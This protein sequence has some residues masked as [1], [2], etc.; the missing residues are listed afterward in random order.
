MMETHLLKHKESGKYYRLLGHSSNMQE[1]LLA[2][3]PKLDKVSGEL[4][5]IFLQELE[6]QYE[7]IRSYSIR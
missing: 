6:E 5:R 1:F 7:Y 2:E 4:K 3:A